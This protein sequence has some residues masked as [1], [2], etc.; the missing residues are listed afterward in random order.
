MT[1]ISA[2]S[3]TVALAANAA[4]Q[5]TATAAGNHS[6]LGIYLKTDVSCTLYVQFSNDGTNFDVVHTYNVDATRYPSLAFSTRVPITSAYFR[7]RV[8]CG[9]VA[10]TLMRLHCTAFGSQQAVAP[11]V[12]GAQA[13]RS[14]DLA[15]TPLVISSTPARLHSVTLNNT[16]AAWSHAKIYNLAVGITVGTTVPAMTLSCPPGAT[17]VWQPEF[18]MQFSTAISA[19]ATAEMDDTGTT[20]PSADLSIHATFSNQ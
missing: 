6:E 12:G 7:T 19:A 1:T 13:A 16:S 20:A 2:C 10:Q 4:F 9:A 5:G 3:S 11:M 17:V 15:L 8:L 18:G 14:Q